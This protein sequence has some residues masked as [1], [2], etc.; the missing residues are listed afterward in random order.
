LTD[1]LIFAIFGRRLK[2]GGLRFRRDVESGLPF[3]Y[4][5]SFGNDNRAAVKDQD[6]GVVLFLFW[7]LYFGIWHYFKRTIKP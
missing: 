2:A 7:C 3:V 1:L 6:S 4:E 5:G